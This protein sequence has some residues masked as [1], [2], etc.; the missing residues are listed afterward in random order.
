MSTILGEV[1]TAPTGYKRLSR[2]GSLGGR[3]IFLELT[4]TLLGS[5]C[6]QYPLFGS[7]RDCH[8]DV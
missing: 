7:D 1:Q 3:G 4:L 8:F 2:E 5:D 6:D